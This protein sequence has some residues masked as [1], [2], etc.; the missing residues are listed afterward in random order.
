[1]ASGARLVELDLSDNAIGPTAISGISEFLASEAASSLQVLKLNNCGLGVAGKVEYSLLILIL[2]FLN[3]KEQG[4]YLQKAQILYSKMVSK[5]SKTDF[6][7]KAQEFKLQI[8]RFFIFLKKDF[9]LKQFFIQKS[10]YS[11]PFLVF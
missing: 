9:D 11:L 8:L 3:S 2:V 4:F 6:L 5:S 7:K 10:P 1:M